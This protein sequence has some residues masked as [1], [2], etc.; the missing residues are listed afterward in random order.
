MRIII[1]GQAPFGAQVLE[2]LLNDGEQVV[3]AYC[4][5]DRPNGRPD[6]M[7]EAA[8]SRGIP[9]VQPSS[10]KDDRVFAR[11]CE[12]EPDL[13]VLAFVT[14]IIPARFFER[15]VHGAICYHPSILP[16]HRGASA[17]NWAVIMGDTK[18]G[19]TVFRPDGGIDTGPILLQ[20][21]VEIGPDDTTG[22]VYFNRLFPM[23]TDA[24]VE[25][26]RLIRE[27]TAPSRPQPEEGATYE[28]PCNDLVAGVD[29]SGSPAE[30]FNLIRGC[31]PQPG[32]YSFL[33]GEKIRFY[34]A[35]LLPVPPDAAPGTIVA[36][37]S[38][39]FHISAGEATLVVGAIRP[40][41]GGKV[42]PEAYASEHGI[43]PGRCFAA[44]T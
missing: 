6:P 23:G 4:P 39:G 43:S 25:S 8:V 14:D 32:A 10:Y 31:D 22:S 33:D 29:W 13:T 16:R 37:D 42:A 41:G 12:Y 26:V 5:P 40:P 2:A 15:A 21:E 11:Y 28:P 9:V 1:I 35:R 18:T 3:A 19:L 44:A 20:K 30:I 27:G 38:E 24:L 17:I 7:K 34:G 36:V